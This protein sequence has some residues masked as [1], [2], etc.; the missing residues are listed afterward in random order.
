M[1]PHPKKSRTASGAPKQVRPP[2]PKF[3]RLGA[4][5]A[6]RTAAFSEDQATVLV[7]TLSEAQFHLATKDDLDQAVG[8]LRDE[9]KQ[10]EAGIRGDMTQMETGIR[11]DMAQMEAGIR[12]DMKEMEA[13]IRHDMVK[14]EAGL[15]REMQDLRADMDD[16]FQKVQWFILSSFGGATGIISTVVVFAG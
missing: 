7:E 12:H 16:K 14:M 9:M 6:L 1:E 10:M 11:A 5:N 8:T 2:L 15:R 4:M 13:G 3:D